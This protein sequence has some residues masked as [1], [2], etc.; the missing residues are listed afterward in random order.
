MKMQRVIGT[1][2]RRPCAAMLLVG[3]GS[4]LQMP[5][6]R[7]EGMSTAATLLAG[8]GIGAGAAL[9]IRSR[10]FSTN[11]THSTEWQ[12][13]LYMK[14]GCPFCSNLAIWLAST[15]LDK[16]FQWEYDTVENRA[17]IEALTASL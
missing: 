17:L 13:I 2:A 8:V 7:C 3:G 9:S 5:H 15:G 4:L 12:P 10:A 11:G 1:L 16:H 6:T 14:P